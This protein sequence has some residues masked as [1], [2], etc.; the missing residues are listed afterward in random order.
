[1]EDKLY[2]K[3][4]GHDIAFIEWQ[5]SI[6]RMVNYTVCK[7]YTVQYVYNAPSPPHHPL[8]FLILPTW[9]LVSF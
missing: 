5:R 7:L 1:M 6:G 9:A 8:Y 2:E 4:T 3:A